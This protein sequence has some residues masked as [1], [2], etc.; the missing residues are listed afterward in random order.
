MNRAHDTAEA[1]QRYCK[2]QL[3]GWL[4]PRGISPTMRLPAVS[5]AETDSV[6]FFS[7]RRNLEPNDTGRDN[8]TAFSAKISPIPC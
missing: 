8:Q 3:F 2:S 1:L 4:I 7:G 6:E 5:P